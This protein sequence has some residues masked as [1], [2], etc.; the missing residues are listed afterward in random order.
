MK[1]YW[2]KMS[3]EW[4]CAAKYAKKTQEFRD[5][6][7]AAVLRASVAPTVKKIPVG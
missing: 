7:K 4:R 2:S 1:G 3:K 6:V 5:V